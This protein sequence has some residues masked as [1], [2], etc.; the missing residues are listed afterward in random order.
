MSK[1]FWAVSLAILLAGCQGHNQA[2]GAATPPPSSPTAVATTTPSPQASESPQSSA[3]P[4][5]EEE[6]GESSPENAAKSLEAAR[7]ADA[8]PDYPVI[9][10]LPEGFTSEM[11]GSHEGTAV[12]VSGAGGQVHI[13]IPDPEISATGAE[14]VTGPGG[15]LESNEWSV[16]EAGRQSQPAPDWMSESWAFFGPD[17]LEGV[18]W[19]GDFQGTQVRVTASAPAEQLDAFYEKIGPMIQGMEFRK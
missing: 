1:L 7:A 16:Q 6:L 17:N 19:L 5:S 11:F 12:M 4:N 15:L 2:G 13:F 9:L 3:S 18:V 10:A 8:N 14:S